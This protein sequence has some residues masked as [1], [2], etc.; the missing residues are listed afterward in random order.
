ML[1][2]K[3]HRV[4][5]HPKGRI[6]MC[7]GESHK[8]VSALTSS[9]IAPKQTTTVAYWNVRTMLQTGKTQQLTQEMKRY[10]VDICGISECRWKGS[11]KVQ[12]STGENHNILGETM[13]NI[14]F[15]IP[16]SDEC[17]ADWEPI[18]DRMIKSNFPD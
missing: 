4:M 8:E 17:L 10:K 11:G 14:I 7:T 6:M 18:N 12:L 9:L 5:N 16:E 1:N 15:M 3:D 13:T 2:I